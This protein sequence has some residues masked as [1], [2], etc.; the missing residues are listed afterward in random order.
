[1]RVIYVYLKRHLDA[2]LE[3]GRGLETDL[4]VTF[5]ICSKQQSR[6]EQQQSYTLH[7]PILAAAERGDRSRT[8]P[9]RMGDLQYRSM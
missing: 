9:N 4:E 1:M 2:R 8:K 7:A 5:T 6:D 3:L